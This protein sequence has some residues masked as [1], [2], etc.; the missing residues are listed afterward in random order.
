MK[1]E[2]K[3]Y[4]HGLWFSY[5][6]SKVHFVFYAHHLTKNICFWEKSWFVKH[7]KIQQ[8]KKQLCNSMNRVVGKQV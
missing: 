1:G 8:L 2:K 6:H 5:Q 4:G 7:M 3:A